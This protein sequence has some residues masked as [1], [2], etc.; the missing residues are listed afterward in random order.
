VL[1]GIFQSPG[2]IRV[3]GLVISASK[4]VLGGHIDSLA[5]FVLRSNRILVTLSKV[6]GPLFA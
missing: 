2:D 6:K 4:E 5:L 1:S 3:I